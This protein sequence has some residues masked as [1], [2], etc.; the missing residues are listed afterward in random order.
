MAFA[1]PGSS[2]KCCQPVT[3]WPSGILRLMTP[4]RSRKTVRKG[5]SW[6]VAEVWRRSFGRVAHPAMINNKE[7]RS[8]PDRTLSSFP[9]RE[10]MSQHP[11]RETVFTKA[12]AEHLEVIRGVEARQDVLEAIARAMADALLL[13]NQILWCGNGGSAG[14]SQHL[15]AEIVGRFRPPRTTRHALHRIDHRHLI[16]TA[17]PTTMAMKPSS[18]PGGSVGAQG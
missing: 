7:L 13:G 3:Y 10:R 4:S 2:S 17:V 8:R 1:T 5:S 18:P 15:A 16:L 14:D 11:D 6:A 9:Q 12:I